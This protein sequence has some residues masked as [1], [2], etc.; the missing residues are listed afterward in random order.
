MDGISM[1]LLMLTSMISI[2]ALLAWAS[3]TNNLGVGPMIAAKLAGYP[4][5][6]VFCA[7]VPIFALF[8]SVFE[9]IAF[10][11]VMQEALKRTFQSLAP[12]LLL[13]AS[14]FAALHFIAG[15]PNGFIGILL[16]FFY[17][18]ALG[19]LRERTGGTLSPVLAHFVTGMTIF[20]WLIIR[21][22]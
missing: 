12:A 15:F 14:V 22:L 1:K 21:F 8:N 2:V 3:W 19:Y 13:Q 11:G 6:M 18:L 20:Y 7:V 4:S 10:R 9:E 17:A 5:W 16:V